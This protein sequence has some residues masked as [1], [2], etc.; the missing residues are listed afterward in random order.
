M[1]RWRPGSRSRD[2][3][4]DALRVTVLPDEVADA[5]SRPARSTVLPPTFVIS[6][7]SSDA[8]A[9]PVCTSETSSVDTGH[10]TYRGA[11]GI[12]SAR[13]ANTAP[14][15][16]TITDNAANTATRVRSTVLD[17]R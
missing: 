8:D 6:A 4:H 11:P 10:E 17:L 2:V 13:V 7:N 1:N 12:G 14:A 15:T 5:S 3:D 9:P 16:V